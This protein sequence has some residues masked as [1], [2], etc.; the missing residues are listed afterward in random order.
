MC[1]M[2]AELKDLSLNLLHPNPYR[3]LATYPWVEEKIDTLMASYRAVGIFEGVI[4]RPV[5]DHYELWFGHHRHEAAKRSG[6]KSM[7]VIV[8]DATDEMMIKSMAHENA[9]DF[10]TD[11]LIQL[12]TWEGGIK[13]LTA[14][15]R[16]PA[17]IPEALEIA[18]LLGMTRED[19]KG[20]HGDRLN[21]VAMACQSAHALITAG[22]LERRDLRGLSTHAARELT[23][24][25]LSQMKL[26]ENMG[27]LTKADSKSVA[28]GKKFVSTAGKHA[29]EKVRK[30]ITPTSGIRMEVHANTFTSAAKQAKE[31]SRQLPLLGAFAE[32]LRRHLAKI[33]NDDYAAEK[34]AQI[35]K[36]IGQITLEEDHASVRGVQ[37]ELGEVVKRAERWSKRITPS[38]EKVVSLKQLEDKN[39]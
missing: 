23:G 15:A 36:A 13:Y 33:L 17:K 29:A 12:N 1:I 10:G 22:H 34:L 19:D 28:H 32:A 7:P 14:F 9:E 18:R 39:G 25:M 24:A 2:K 30:G 38:R 11:F 5:G 3:D 16:G 8:R 26:V 37:F 21:D 35:H 6:I 20:K 27:K 31:D 4:A